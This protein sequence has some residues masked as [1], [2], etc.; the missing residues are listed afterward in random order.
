MAAGNANMF[1]GDVG[2]AKNAAVNLFMILDA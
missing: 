2:K 1:M